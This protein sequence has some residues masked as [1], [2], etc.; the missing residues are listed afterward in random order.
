MK[1]VPIRVATTLIFLLVALPFVA[2]AE[3]RSS[4]DRDRW[5]PWIGCWEG[6]LQPGE[7]EDDRFLVCFEFI[8]DEMGVELVTY[9]AGEVVARE[10]LRADGL[11]SPAEEGGCVGERRAEWSGGGDR[12]YLHSELRCAEDLSRTSRGVLTFLPDGDAWM[13]IH[14][15]RTGE[16]SPVLGIRSF[17]PAPR[18]ALAD[19][20]IGDPAAGLELAVSAARS[21]A[22]RSLAADDVVELVSEV[23][24][25]ATGAL[26]VERGDVFELDARTLKGMA[27]RGVSEDVLDVMVALAYPDRFEIEGREPALRAEE[28]P[29]ARAVAPWPAGRSGA[30]MGISVFRGYSPWGIGFYDPYWHDSFRYGGYGYGMSGYRYPRVLVVQPPTV[31]DRGAR[32]NP[33]EGYRAGSESTRPSTPATQRSAPSSSRSPRPSANRS[34]DRG[35]SASPTPSSTRG[36]SQV[37]PGGHSA[38]DSGGGQRRARPRPDSD[39]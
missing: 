6:A 4:V 14:A 1:D 15:V 19:H 13:E 11:P 26:L 38:G 23:G 24:S 22:G 5:L 32:V 33:R 3:D 37:S 30:R 28:R 34:P 31:R 17:R 7:E 20:G 10:E 36:G 35:A 27:D 12:L 39:G 9:Q 21:R 29:T 18:S 2:T 16:A 8:G 25:A